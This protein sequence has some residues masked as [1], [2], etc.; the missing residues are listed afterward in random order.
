MSDAATTAIS[1]DYVSGAGGSSAALGE[2]S[3][4]LREFVERKFG[5]AGAALRQLERS[6]ETRE[7]LSLV[8][9]K[10]R[11]VRAWWQN[12]NADGDANIESTRELDLLLMQVRQHVKSNGIESYG[13]YV[14]AVDVDV[15]F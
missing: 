13:Q 6:I 4:R 7:P 2:A 3:L 11:G 12:R 8:L 5:D 10:L 1:G 9:E 15:T 14:F